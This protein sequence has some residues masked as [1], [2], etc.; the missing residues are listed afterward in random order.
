VALERLCSLTR[1]LSV[2]V[3]KDD[4]EVAWPESSVQETTHLINNFKGMVH[5]LADQ[6]HEVKQI[7]ET[8]EK[9]VEERTEELK[10][11]EERFRNMANSAPVLIWVAGTDKLCNWFNQVWLDFTGRSMEQEAG[12]GWAEGVHPDDL[13][14]CLETYVTAFDNRQPFSMEYRL[15][16]ANGQYCWLI[17]NGSPLFKQEVFKGYI[18]SCTDI[19]DSKRTEEALQ[20]SEEDLHEKNDDLLAKEEMLR[21]QIDEYE[22]IQSQLQVAKADAESANAAKS[23]FLA[24]MSHEIRTPMNGVLGMTQLLELTE[25]TEEQREY[26]VSLKQCGK[27]LMSLISD[28]LDLSKIEAGKILIE[29]VAFSLKQCINDVVVMQKFVLYEKGL[30]LEIDVSDTIPHLLV[31]DQFRLKQILLNLMGNAVKFTAQG[32]ITVSAHLLE[33][34]DH[35]ALVKI[36]VRDTGVGISPEAVDKIFQ[37][38]TQEDGSISRKYGGTGLGLTISQR[39]AELLGGAIAVESTPGVGSCFNVTLPFTIGTTVVAAHVEPT[40]TSSYWDGPPL[41]ILLV[42]DD[43]VNI[44]FGGSLLKRVGHSVTT[45]EDGKKCLAALEKGVFDI[46]LMDVQM[47]VMNGEEALHEIRTKEQGTTDHLSVIALTA[48]SMRGDKD[49]LQ[50]A[51]FDGYVSKPLYIKDLMEEMKRVWEADVKGA[52]NH[53]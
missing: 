12:N 7:N 21:N 51:G 43:Q 32:S 46:V 11:S 30:K 27:N 52:K 1:D 39:L 37:P 35:S 44:K 13:D 50:E 17:D 49:R 16:K 25:L 48:H 3:A 31:G 41:R 23:Q 26:T 22:V 40:I 42:D 2:R 14:R 45:A 18:G 9:R 6:F 5:S 24:N 10:E 29:V 20:A 33:Q 36:A 28:I 19:N 15:R 53:G 8:L 4:Y 38:F 47:P 34:H